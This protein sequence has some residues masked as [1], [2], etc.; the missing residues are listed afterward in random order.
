MPGRGI[1]AS[2]AT[3]PVS[4]PAVVRVHR[5]DIPKARTRST[6]ALQQQ[7]TQRTR[8]RAGDR[9]WRLEEKLGASCALTRCHSSRIP[10]GGD[11]RVR[12]DLGPRKFG[13]RRP[14][15]AAQSRIEVETETGLGTVATASQELS[16]S[17]ARLEEI[18][19]QLPERLAGQLK[20]LANRLD[21]IQG[22][23]S[24]LK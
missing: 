1:P 5:A 2:E 23:V 12:E 13:C 6:D 20:E 10:G 11:M 7:Q 19:R 4:V 14:S 22:K 17:S 18:M 3:N 15:S 8:R 9:S 21:T 16:A 24:S